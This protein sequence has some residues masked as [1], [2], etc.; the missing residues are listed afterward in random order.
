MLRSWAGVRRLSPELVLAGRSRAE[1]PG[2]DVLARVLTSPRLRSRPRAR[3]HV[4][5]MKF[6]IDLMKR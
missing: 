1:H 4:H 2:Q 3:Q 6:T 5:Q